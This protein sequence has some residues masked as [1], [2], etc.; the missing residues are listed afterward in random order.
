MAGRAHPIAIVVWSSVVFASVGCAVSVIGPTLLDLAG[1]LTVEIDVVALVFP[2]RAIGAFIGTA[3]SGFV[4]DRF[5]RYS[6]TMIA[7]IL[8]LGAAGAQSVLLKACQKLKRLSTYVMFLHF[9]FALGATIAPLWAGFLVTQGSLNGLNVSWPGVNSSTLWNG[10][11]CTN[12]TLNTHPSRSNESTGSS[13]SANITC[14]EG[15]MPESSALFGWAYWL[16]APLFLTA[17]AAFLY[18]S[19]KLE[20]PIHRMTLREYDIIT[21]A[22][23]EPS[24]ETEER[25]QVY[26]LATQ[27]LKFKVAFFALT[28]LLA[29]L[30][31]AIEACVTNYLFTYAVQGAHFAKERA[32]NLNFTYWG[33]FAMFRLLAVLLSF[34]KIPSAT[35]IIFNLSG[36]LLTSLMMSFF[37]DNHTVIWCG[38]VLLGVCTSS[39]FPSIVAWLAQQTEMSGKVSALL[40]CPL[41]LADMSVP[42]T[43]AVLMTRVS[44]R[45]FIYF[46][47]ADYALALLCSVMLFYFTWAR[48]HCA[49]RGSKSPL[50]LCLSPLAS[51]P[52]TQRICPH[53]P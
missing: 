11:D 4:L 16:S 31:I 52:S 39:T 26:F 51:A 37:S 33:V 28:S 8:L 7:A 20:L 43:I 14:H 48:K 38:T 13:P 34:L 3:T 30:S 15:E 41:T 47:A 1:R 23:P 18:Y 24:Q 53:P 27:P 6:Y 44:P 49:R 19:I 21:K 2:V 17:M 36:G 32:A 45:S 5:Q 40:I 46:T 29:Y 50:N 22:S 12:M 25:P 42:L 10:K 9:C 35:L